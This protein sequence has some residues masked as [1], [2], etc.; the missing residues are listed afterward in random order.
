ML[1]CALGTYSKNQAL[2]ALNYTSQSRIQFRLAVQLICLF[3]AMSRSHNLR[4][5]LL[6]DIP[7]DALILCCFNQNKT[8]AAS[9]KNESFDLEQ[10]S[11]QAQTVRFPV[12][13]FV[14]E[15]YPLTAAMFE[16]YRN[17]NQLVAVTDEFVINHYS[18]ETVDQW[19]DYLYNGNQ[20]EKLDAAKSYKAD[21]HAM[22]R[23]FAVEGLQ[24]L[25]DEL[26]AKEIRNFSSKASNKKDSQDFENTL[27]GYLLQAVN[28]KAF[29]SQMTV[30]NAFLGRTD[31]RET[32]L[33]SMS[34]D[35][36][37]KVTDIA[38]SNNAKGLH[39]LVHACH[40]ELLSCSRVQGDN[41]CDLFSLAI[42]TNCVLLTYVCFDYL[43]EHARELVQ[44][45]SVAL[46][47]MLTTS[48]DAV[49]LL[50]TTK[51]YRLLV[52]A[53][54]NE[55]EDGK[56]SFVRET[57]EHDMIGRRRAKLEML[58]GTFLSAN[59][60]PTPADS[61]GTFQETAR[62]ESSDTVTANAFSVTA[63]K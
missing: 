35:A 56:A 40:R 24:A 20:S 1:T 61:D 42:K 8:I 28:F 4:E 62:N 54:H 33:Q 49:V 60:N 45:Q 11:I 27:I 34:S 17:S 55:T 7:A 57:I 30:C 13:F 26:L 48:P 39:S 29:L 12:H 31:G 41:V 32:F 25:C 63:T 37:R 2:F 36:I 53:I 46:R 16:K 18:P 52:A 44:T 38:A 22:A 59:H 19:L 14:I 10:E 21:L 51:L 6:L 5:E 15:K 43:N 23:E 58:L 50:K 47:K 3:C 9:S